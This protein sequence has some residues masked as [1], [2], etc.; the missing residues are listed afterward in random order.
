M[1]TRQMMIKTISKYD[2]MLTNIEHL[3]WAVLQYYLPSTTHKYVSDIS[4]IKK[5]ESVRQYWILW[6]D[7]LSEI[8][9][10]NIKDMN[11]KVV[12]ECRNCELGSTVFH[13]YRLVK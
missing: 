11:L 12:E 7:S 2:V 1:A 9:L 6:S 10:N 3:E 8:D 13:L 5:L 4:E